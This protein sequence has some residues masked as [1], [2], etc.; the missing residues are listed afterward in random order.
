MFIL[1]IVS[2][3]TDPF[4]FARSEYFEITKNA[5]NTLKAFDKKKVYDLDGNAFTA[6]YEVA[7]NGNDEYEDDAGNTASPDNVLRT[8]ATL[9]EV[10][11][12]TKGVENV[13]ALEVEYYT[14]G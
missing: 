10:L 13:L 2:A 11:T 3:E 1:F 12:A 5:Y 6:F 14:G 4:E 7:V 8:F 9:Q